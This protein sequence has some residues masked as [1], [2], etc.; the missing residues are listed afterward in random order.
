MSAAEKLKALEVRYDTDIADLPDYGPAD[1]YGLHL[2]RA[3]PQLVAVV[4]WVEEY[5][6][7]DDWH[8][9]VGTEGGRIDDEVDALL[10]ALD[11]A[12]G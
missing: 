9:Y 4:T 3:L 12:L 7:A 6:N 5:S 2:K 11:E 8:A 10:A 1:E